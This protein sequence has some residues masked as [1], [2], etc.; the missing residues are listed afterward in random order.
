VAKALETTP[1]REAT[2][3]RTVAPNMVT[4]L[5]PRPATLVA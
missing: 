2:A 1:D 4:L 3:T 5:I